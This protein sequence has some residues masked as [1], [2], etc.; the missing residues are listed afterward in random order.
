MAT[1]KEMLDARDRGELHIVAPNTEQILKHATRV[2]RG[3]VPLG[4]RRELSAAVKAG[5]LGHFRKDGL[6]P[7]IYFDPQHRN[8]AIERRRNEAEYAIECI[9]KVLV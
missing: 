8:G 9:K 1:P 4:V 5:I 7:E 6:L 3:R 2:I